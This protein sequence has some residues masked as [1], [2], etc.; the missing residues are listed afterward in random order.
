MQWETSCVTGF[1]HC[2]QDQKLNDSRVY[3]WFKA[4]VWVGILC[5]PACQWVF[6]LSHFAIS[7]PSKS[8]S[9]CSSCSQWQHLKDQ[10]WDVWMTGM[11]QLQQEASE[12]IRDIFALCF[13][14]STLWNL[15]LLREIACYELYSPFQNTQSALPHIISSINPQDSPWMCNLSQR[16]S[17]GIFSRCAL[18][19]AWS[20]FKINT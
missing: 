15:V 12:K 16:E 3:L 9:L 20:C 2:H 18:A 17:S 4:L 13:T 19:R 14:S 8:C 7:P 5:H 11:T 10:M 6:V 1:A